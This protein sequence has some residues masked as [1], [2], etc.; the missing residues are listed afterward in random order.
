LL[1]ADPDLEVVAEAAD[2]GSAVDTL[3]EIRPELVFLDV[4]LPELDGFAV[5]K[6]VVPQYTPL[7]IFVTAYDQY[8]LKAFETH[9]FDYLLKPFKR[10]RLFEAVERAKQQLALSQRSHEQH[11][12]DLLQEL[13]PES[14]RIV[15]R[16]VGKIVVLNADEIDYIHAAA[17]Y[18]RVLAGAEVHIARE[19]LSAFA[20]SLPPEKF[21]RIHRSIVVNVDR[22]RELQ[23]CGGSECVIVLRDRRELPVGRSY[24]YA[25]EAALHLG[26]S[27]D[28]GP[29][30]RRA[31]F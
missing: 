21:V 13:K 29:I 2:G 6:Y 28:R 14:K 8:A 25:V 24:K 17:N 3:L 12:R 15:I 18:V 19:T 27:D 16:T 20:Q 10:H 5:L 23:P 22:I 31:N 1:S 9:A 7:V 26:K 4:Q 30:G 11:M